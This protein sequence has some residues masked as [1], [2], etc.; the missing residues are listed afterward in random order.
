MLSRDSILGTNRNSLC[1]TSRPAL[2][3]AK[4]PHQFVLEPSLWEQNGH[5]A[6]QN[7]HLHAMPILRM[8]RTSV[9][10]PVQAS[11]LS[12][13]DFIFALCTLF[14]GVFNNSVTSIESYILLG[15]SHVHEFKLYLI[16]PL[17]TYFPLLNPAE[18]HHY[19][20]TCIILL[21][22]LKF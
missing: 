22:S 12:T 1:T 2:G 17:R 16:S 10:S 13:V 18:L 8:H 5:S 21:P 15:Y 6:K 14:Y 19:H 4:I 20:V 7:I 9:S 3:L 11:C